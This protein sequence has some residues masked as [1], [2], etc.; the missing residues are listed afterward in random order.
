MKFQDGDIVFVRN[1][2]FMM[3]LSA[4]TSGISHV[5]MIYIDNN[6]PYLSSMSRVKNRC[7]HE[8]ICKLKNWNYVKIIRLNPPLSEEEKEILNEECKKSTNYCVLPYINDGS[9]INCTQHVLK[10]LR[11]IGRAPSYSNNWLLPSSILDL[12][13]E[14]VFE[15]GE[16][17][18]PFLVCM[19][20]LIVL[21]IIVIILLF[22]LYNKKSTIS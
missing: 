22:N 7:N 2:D 9:C 21:I 8:P 17:Y 3:R 15:R 11:K 19:M 18:D 4:I 16:T 6:K 13:Y 10:M 1:K 14:V 20:I 5:S 12:P